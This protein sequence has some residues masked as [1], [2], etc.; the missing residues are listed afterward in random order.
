M[1][2]EIIYNKKFGKISIFVKAKPC[3]YIFSKKSGSGKTLLVDT[4]NKRM[5]LNDKEA[6]T[7][8]YQEF[9]GGVNFNDK[10][11]ARPN[12]KLI[13]I[14]R[15]DMMQG[16]FLDIMAKYKDT[17][18]ILV[19]TKDYIHNSHDYGIITHYIPIVYRENS[20]EVIQR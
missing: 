17:S 15:Y 18:I 7:Y 9:I 10:L 20:I 1:S 11:K 12:P 13:V 5:T 6:V 2:N 16:K 3:V 8:S 14:D 4:I 19:D